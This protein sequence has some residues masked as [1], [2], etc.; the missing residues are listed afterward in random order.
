MPKELLRRKKVNYIS[1]TREYVKLRNPK[2][3]YI[4]VIWIMEKFI[5][6]AAK[7]LVHGYTIRIKDN[8]NFSLF[9]F[10]SDQYEKVEKEYMYTRSPAIHGVFFGVG[11]TGKMI[12]K[13]N[14]TFKPAKKFRALMSEELDDPDLAYKL[15]ST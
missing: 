7:M 8:F 5:I 11:C 3:R 2:L 13:F 12:D 4:D 6:Y 1:T 10:T 15:I 14:P 9:H